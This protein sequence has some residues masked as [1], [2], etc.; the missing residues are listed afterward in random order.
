MLTSAEEHW[1]PVPGWEG[2]YEVSNHGRVVSLTRTVQRSNGAGPKPVPER[3]LTP[4]CDRSGRL[5][6]RLCRDSKQHWFSVRR[7]VLEAF[8]DPRPPAQLSQQPEKTSDFADQ[9]TGHSCFVARF[10]PI[11]PLES[12]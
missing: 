10:S 7:L 11:Q 1:L 2:L 6:V 5:R 3:V 8:A 9:A 4:K 12:P